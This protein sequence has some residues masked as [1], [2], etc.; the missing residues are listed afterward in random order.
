DR[1][2]SVAGDRDEDAARTQH[3]PGSIEGVASDRVDDRVHASDPILETSR[4][5]VHYLVGTEFLQEL[6][7]PFGGGPDDVGSAR[8]RELDGEGADPA[9]GAVDEDAVAR[10]HARVIEQRLPR[11]EAG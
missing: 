5:I 3:G 2:R 9:R 7:I 1:F 6:D 11:R 8:V 10:G 4:G